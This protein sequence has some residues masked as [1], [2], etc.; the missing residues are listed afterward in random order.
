MYKFIIIG[1]IFINSFAQNF[2]SAEIKYNAI[3]TN[4]E[5]TDTQSSKSQKL[6]K[7]LN[8]MSKDKEFVLKINTKGFYFTETKKMQDDKT[9]ILNSVGNAMF[10]VYNFFYLKDKKTLIKEQGSDQI[11]KDP[12]YNWKFINETK[13]IDKFLCH[14]AECIIKFKNRN[15]EN[16]SKKITAWYAPS[17]NFNY[18]P[19][20]YMG[21]PGLILELEYNKTK[22][23]A[24]EVKLFKDDV[25]IKYPKI[26]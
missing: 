6:F 26:K 7:I 1:F 11:K 10:S 12:N 8:D 23:V 2:K 20:G 4:L 15:G 3:Y 16:T 21:L 17:I 24:K 22:L 25:L 18:G 9:K 13:K 14:K 5:I 19:N